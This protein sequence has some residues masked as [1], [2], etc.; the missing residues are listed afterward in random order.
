MAVTQY[1][2]ARYVP[3]LA[4]PMEWSNDRA[5]EPLTIVLHQGN[6]Y[7]SRQAVPIGIDIT[8]ETYWA[9]T[10]NYN[11]QVEQYRQEVKSY[12]AKVD[13]TSTA[14]TAETDRAK[15]AEQAN[16]EAIATETERAKEVER[17][18][19]E[20]IVAETARA[21]K[22]EEELASVRMA[23]P[24]ASISM[25]LPIVH[26]K[27]GQYDSSQGSA[28]VEGGM[29]AIAYQGSGQANQIRL[30]SMSSGQL[31]SS[32]TMAND[33]NLNSLSAH[34]TTV[35]CCGS[36]SGISHISRVYELSAAGGQLNLVRTFDVDASSAG[37]TSINGFGWY[38]AEHYWMTE[39]WRN[40]YLCNTNL[41]NITKLCTVPFGDPVRT[42]QGGTYD[43]THKLFIYSTERCSIFFDATGKVVSKCPFL[44]IYNG[45]W[46]GEVEQLSYAPD[47][48]CYYFN[49]NSPV[50]FQKFDT[51]KLMTIWRTKADGSE[52]TYEISPGTG[53]EPR[54][55][56]NI[57][58][59]NPEIQTGERNQLG[60][61]ECRYAQDALAIVMGFDNLNPMINVYGLDK[62]FCVFADKDMRVWTSTVDLRGIVQLGGLCRYNLNGSLA[63]GPWSREALISVEQGIPIVNTGLPTL[64]ASGKYYLN[65]YQTLVGLKAGAEG[66][67]NPGLNLSSCARLTLS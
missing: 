50:L 64:T 63:T 44:P 4:D 13:Q 21:K 58:P 37:F 31:L 20:A 45:F 29:F 36:H 53:G 51:A 11:A 41:G 6:S 65:A 34:G 2:G 40:I 15:E 67:D 48:D 17:D 30:Y 57:R 23:M 66:V 38:D 22:A 42:W 26:T 1:I 35:Y 18:N 32:Y 12:D 61:V 24:P 9:A 5:Y 39:S 59:T 8:D 10:G 47:Q 54:T 62:D 46:T 19:T 60:I 49:T 52:A 14:L 28:Y 33:D 16:A 56:I 27:I 55:M 7:T 43:Y 25:A 3:L